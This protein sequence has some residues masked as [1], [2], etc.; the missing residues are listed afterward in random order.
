ML[1]ISS[2][3]AIWLNFRELSG[4]FQG[5]F[6]HLYYFIFNMRLCTTMLHFKIHYWENKRSSVMCSMSCPHPCYSIPYTA[7]LGP[8][9]RHS[10]PWAS[11]ESHLLGLTPLWKPCLPLG[12][13]E[14]Q[15]LP[16]DENSKNGGTSLARSGYKDTV[17]SM[18]CVLSRSPWWMPAAPWRIHVARNCSLWPVAARIRGC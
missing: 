6:W 16:S 3:K 12:C 5:S 18:L 15:W 13:G 10:S 11:S 8:P 14:T 2:Q 9:V 4:F 17:A 1:L 7:L